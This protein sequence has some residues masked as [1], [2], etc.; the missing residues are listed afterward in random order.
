MH[1]RLCSSVHSP[2]RQD[3]AHPANHCMQCCAVGCPTAYF[4]AVNMQPCPG[5]NIHPGTAK[6]KALDLAAPDELL[7]MELDC[8]S[9][10]QYHLKTKADKCCV[11]LPS[12][13]KVVQSEGCYRDSGEMN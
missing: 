12:T 1:L 7:I 5:I 11:R 8:P 6:N 13:C 9:A 2:N 3:L 10:G 4:A